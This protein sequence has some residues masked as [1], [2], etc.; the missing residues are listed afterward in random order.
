[1]MKTILIIM[2][3][4][5]LPLGVHGEQLRRTPGTYSRQ[6]IK[7]AI[8]T[9]NFFDKTM[10][11]KGFFKND[12][13]VKIVKNDTVVID[14]RTNLVWH[15]SGSPDFIALKKIKPYIQSV[16]DSKYAGY[17]DWRLPTIEELSSLLKSE[18]SEGLYISPVFDRKQI[19]CWSSDKDNSG[20]RWYVFFGGGTVWCDPYNFHGYVRLVRSM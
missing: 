2:A 10:N 14:R 11:V 16:N 9:N 1:M 13:E 19:F 7:K 3:F 8:A 12:F 6:E 15:Q 18:K 4:L 20:A 17:S 5:L